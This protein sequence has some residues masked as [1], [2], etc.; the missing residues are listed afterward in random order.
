MTDRAAD[1]QMT[2]VTKLPSE[3][4]KAGK[5]F[6]CT[7]FGVGMT[8]RADRRAA[9][10]AELLLMT[11][12]ARRVTAAARKADLCRVRIALMAQQ[13]RHSSVRLTAVIELRVIELCLVRIHRGRLDCRLYVAVRL[14]CRRRRLIRFRA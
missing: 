11:A 12:D 3:R 5:A 9:A 2:R 14:S 8:D 13:T 7:A 10:R 1:T 4:T 6:H